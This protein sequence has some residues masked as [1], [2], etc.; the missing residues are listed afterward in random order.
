MSL[1]T[2]FSVQDIESLQSR[3]MKEMEELFHIQSVKERCLNDLEKARME[4]AYI[5]S[6][7]HLPPFTPSPRHQLPHLAS[8]QSLAS[9]VSD[10]AVTLSTVLSSSQRPPSMVYSSGGN[11][12][13]AAAGGSGGT[14]AQQQLQP[15]N[16][17]LLVA[18]QNGVGSAPGG[19][20]SKQ[21]PGGKSSEQ[22]YVPLLGNKLSPPRRS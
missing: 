20:V 13:S 15:D 18:A 22:D 9:M 8:S 17:R 12:H 19:L 6:F 7:R 10:P 5:E 1:L 4:M 2:Y 16:P 21:V 3:K 14:T 11:L